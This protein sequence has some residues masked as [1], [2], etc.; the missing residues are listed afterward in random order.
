MNL[1]LEKNY[2]KQ[3]LSYL[4]GLDE[5]GRGPLAGPVCTCG[6][7]IRQDSPL[8][9]DFI[10]L[11]RDSKK[12]S[13]TK[14]EYIYNKIFEL[15]QISFGVSLIDNKTIDKIGI[16][17]AIFKSFQNSIK[18]IQQKTKI[19]PNLILVDGNQKIPNLTFKQE[20]II[21]G[22]D[23]I[24]SIALA[25]VIAKH[26]RDTLM[27]KLSKKYPQYD[28]KVNKGYG[29]KKHI[30]VLKEFGCSSLHRKSFKF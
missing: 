17:K 13:P 27:I 24:F 16:Q 30:K 8:P 4:I 19:N 28:F 1:N 10:N 25:S 3:G 29:T 20:T 2:W 22:D 6:I 7:L 12:I 26:T 9:Q 15:P 5:V 18:K 14:R 11:V 21:K 23:K